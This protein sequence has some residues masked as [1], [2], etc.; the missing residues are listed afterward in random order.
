MTTSEKREIKRLINHLIAF[1]NLDLRPRGTAQKIWFETNLH[2]EIIRD[3]LL[4]YKMPANVR[5]IKI[6]T[7][8]VKDPHCAGNIKLPLECPH[9]STKEFRDVRFEIKIDPRMYSS[10]EGFIWTLTHELSHLVLHGSHNPHK[11]SEVVTDLLVIVYGLDREVLNH[12][13]KISATP[14]YITPQQIAYAASYLDKLRRDE[15]VRQA[16]GLKKKIKAWLS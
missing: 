4:F 5:L 14:G 3:Y 12:S 8:S 10:F 6:D 9:Y 2:G 11:K 1:F 7:S 16:V 13:R 15:R